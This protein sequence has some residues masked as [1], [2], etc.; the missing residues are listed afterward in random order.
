MQ[1]GIERVGQLYGQQ[2]QLVLSEMLSEKDYERPDYSEIQEVI[3][4]LKDTQLKEYIKNRVRCLFI[5]EGTIGHQPEQ[6]QTH[7]TSQQ[8]HEK[9]PSHAIVQ[10]YQT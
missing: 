2:V 1:E 6:D 10:S 4:E 3:D 7:P 8:D 9:L 5:A